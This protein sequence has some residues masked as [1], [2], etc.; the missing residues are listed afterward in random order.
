[1]P[2]LIGPSTPATCYLYPEPDP[3]TKPAPGSS[4]IF[5]FQYWPQSLQVTYTPSYAT[6]EIPGA[7]HP[8]Y[9]WTGGQGRT[10]S[11]EALF[12]SEIAPESLG[13]AAAEGGILTPSRPYTVDVAAAVARIQSYMLPAYKGAGM[14]GT[15]TAPERLVLVFPKTGLSGGLRA[16]GFSAA[17]TLDYVYVLLTGAPVT[18]ES[19]FPDGSPRIASVALTFTEVIQRKGGALTS[20]RYVGREPFAD[21]GNKYNSGRTI[22]NVAGEGI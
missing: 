8:L 1:M 14:N 10:I 12:T 3:G 21:L 11:F 20:I 2:D 5:S 17:P 19:W 18:Y 22:V 9:Q 13:A 16:Q 6:Q 15:I 4:D 7:S